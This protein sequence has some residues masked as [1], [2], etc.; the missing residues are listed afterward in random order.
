MKRRAIASPDGLVE[1]CAQQ[2]TVVPGERNAC[3]AFTMRL[4]EL[5]QTLAC[6]DL[7]NLQNEMTDGN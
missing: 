3:D 5:T 1:G 6:D 7:P 2:L 4:L